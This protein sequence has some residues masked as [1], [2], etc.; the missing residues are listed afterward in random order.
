MSNLVVL[1]AFLWVFGVLCGLLVFSAV[2]AVT[3]VGIL[4]KILITPY[5]VSQQIEEQ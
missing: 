3:L 4:L 2:I 5:I 1:T